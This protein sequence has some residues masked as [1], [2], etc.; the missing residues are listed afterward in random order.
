MTKHVF[1]AVGHGRTPAGVIDSGAR[2]QHQ[3][4]SKSE[5][6]EGGIIVAHLARLLR[7]AG[8]RVTA[9][10]PGDPNFSGR[11][12]YTAEANR[13]QPDLAL[14]VHH[15]WYRA[16]RG[17]FCHWAGGAGTW[18]ERTARQRVNKRAADAMFAAVQQAGTFPMR[19]SW[20]KPRTDLT[21]CTGTRVPAVLIECDRIGEVRDH[22][23]LALA[24]ANGVCDHLGIPRP[25]VDRTITVGDRGPDVAEWN[26]TLARLFPAHPASAT[27]TDRFTAGTVERTLLVLRYAGLTAADPAR[28]RVGPA[29]RDAAA[30]MAREPWA[31]KRVRIKTDGLR[32]YS[33]PGWHPDNR[34]AGAGRAGFWF[35]GG[36]VQ[37][38]TVGAGRQYEVFSLKG[39]GPLYITASPVHVDVL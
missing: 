8:V 31:G 18:L 30:K 17:F 24:I 35:G 13:L 5:Q 12:G 14:S 7:S 11:Q 38:H 32:Y 6:S 3:D 10:R 27:T 34:P 37:L 23:G 19:P 33:T 16:P 22:E 39:A 20:H 1:I 28:P 15:D 9:Q 4:G 29:T 25:P 26:A 21:F 2:N 36:I